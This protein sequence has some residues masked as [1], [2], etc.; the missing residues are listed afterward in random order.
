[1]IFLFVFIQSKKMSATI[2]D[3]FAENNPRTIIMGVL[4]CTPDSFSDAGLYLETDKAVVRALEMIDQGADI[5]D[6]GGES[7]R[8]G[9]QPVLLK[10]E[11]NR[12]IPVIKK[13]REKSDILISIDSCKTAVAEQALK[14]RADI[15]NDISGLTNPKM[16]EVAVSFKS[17]VVIMHMQATPKTMQ[18]NPSYNN[19]IQEIKDFFEKQIKT[20]KKKG[21]EKIIIDP[22]I[23]FGKRLE[24]NIA[25]TK[26]LNEFSQFGCPILYG[27]SRKSFL[28]AITGLDVQSR[29][30]A[31]LAANVVAII[32]GAKIIRVHNVKANKRAAL[33]ADALKK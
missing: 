24:D 30:E 21:I 11:L 8:P 22:G 13:I 15:I 4:N 29:E 18:E 28:G 32:N 27:G 5:I 1:M 23:G 2:K 25:L 31:T 7:S 12:T 19:A 3:I 10:T 9:S 14:N 20:A 17:P 16:Q 6:I 33:V 26:Y